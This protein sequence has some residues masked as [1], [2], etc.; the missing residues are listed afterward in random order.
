MNWILDVAAVLL[1]AH[2]KIL[3]YEHYPVFV[4]LCVG[5]HVIFHTSLHLGVANVT[6]F[7][8]LR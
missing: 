5:K 1:T 3:S 2:L 4:G 6:H 8:P 7:W